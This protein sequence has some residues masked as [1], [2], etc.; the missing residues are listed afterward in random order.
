MLSIGLVVLILAIIVVA[1]WSVTPVTIT[2]TIIPTRSSSVTSPTPAGNLR[3]YNNTD[4][5][6]SYPSNFSIQTDTNAAGGNFLDTPILKVRFPEN[7][8]SNTNFSEAYFVVSRSNEKITSLDCTGFIG[9]PDPASTANQQQTINNILFTDKD[10]TDASAGNIY[11]SKVYRTFHNDTCYE[12]ALT[13]HTGNIHNYDPSVQEFKK[14]TAFDVLHQI[15][16]TFHF[17]S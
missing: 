11:E 6:L 5:T 7:A 12:V 3:I 15:L 14:S 10:L 1:K 16:A 2:P 13:L 17:N 4:F 8:F 9:T